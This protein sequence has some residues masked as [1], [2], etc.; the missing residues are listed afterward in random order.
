LS[1][2]DYDIVE[3]EIPEDHIHRVIRSI[4]SQPPSDVMQVIKHIT[5]REFFRVYSEIKKNTFGVESY[6]LNVILSK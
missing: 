5:V 3:F 2:Y 6:G 1:G 4:L